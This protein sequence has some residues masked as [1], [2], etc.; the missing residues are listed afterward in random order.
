MT[1][2][3]PREAALEMIPILA[4]MDRQYSS[5]LCSYLMGAVAFDE[6]DR[7]ITIK[8]WSEDH[9]NLLRAA[10]AALD[11]VDMDDPRYDMFQ[12]LVDNF[13]NQI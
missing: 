10:E 7:N 6:Y 8:P 2:Q 9:D 12:E 13:E 11:E 1:I 4:D 3:L 5:K